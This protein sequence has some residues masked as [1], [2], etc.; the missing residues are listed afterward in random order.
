M[1]SPGEETDGNVDQMEKR[2]LANTSVSTTHEV[3][4][5]LVIS[6]ELLQNITRGNSNISYTSVKFSPFVYSFDFISELISENKENLLDFKL[7][8]CSECILSPG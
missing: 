4:N 5:I 2:G 3:W 6:F 1:T 8:Q 7:L